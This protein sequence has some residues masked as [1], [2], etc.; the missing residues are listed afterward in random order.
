M[1]YE[2]LDVV[3]SYDYDSLTEKLSKIYL[4]AYF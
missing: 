2:K 4:L 3:D 1:G